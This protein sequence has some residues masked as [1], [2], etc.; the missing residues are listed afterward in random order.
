[1]DITL[2]E[3]LT[4]DHWESMDIVV[5]QN[6]IEIHVQDYGKVQMSHADFDNIY[7]KIIQ[8]R[9]SCHEVFDVEVS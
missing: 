3:K 2:E 7:E 1:M 4:N 8:Y 9:R 6:S 5:E